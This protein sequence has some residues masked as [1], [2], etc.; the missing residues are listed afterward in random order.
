MI[1]VYK[2]RSDRALIFKIK[3]KSVQYMW[4]KTAI[5]SSGPSTIKRWKNLID[6]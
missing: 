4:V 5:H 3:I 1:S 6:C 2:L